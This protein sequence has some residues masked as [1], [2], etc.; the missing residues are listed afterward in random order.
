MHAHLT[1]SFQGVN[2]SAASATKALEK[3]WR[4]ALGDPL[5]HGE[6][7]ISVALFGSVGTPLVKEHHGSLPKVL[8]MPLRRWCVLQAKA[9]GLHPKDV[10]GKSSNLRVR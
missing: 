2:G 8:G 5:L 4:S 3:A 9:A 6:T 10:P 1:R 7:G